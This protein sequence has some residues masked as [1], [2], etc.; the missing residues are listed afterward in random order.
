MVTIILVGRRR[1]RR[2]L[3]YYLLLLIGCAIVRTTKT[4]ATTRMFVI[5]G[6]VIHL[7]FTT[8]KHLSYKV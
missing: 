3:H 7:D 1:R 8:E 4:L 5:A 6:H 2:C